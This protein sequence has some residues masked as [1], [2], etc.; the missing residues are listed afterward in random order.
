MRVFNLNNWMSCALLID[1]RSDRNKQSNQNPH[2]LLKIHSNC[3]VDANSIST[4]SWMKTLNK[5]NNTLNKMNVLCLESPTSQNQIN[6]A[7]AKKKEHVAPITNEIIDLIRE[8]TTDFFVETGK[9][10]TDVCGQMKKKAAEAFTQRTDE[11]EAISEEKIKKKS[12]RLKKIKNYLVKYRF[13]FKD[14]IS[15]FPIFLFYKQ[16]KSELIIKKL[17]QSFNNDWYE[18]HYNQIQNLSLNKTVFQDKD[19]GD[20]KIICGMDKDPHLKLTGIAKI[21]HKL[22]KQFSIN[23]LGIFIDPYFISKKGNKLIAEH[24]VDKRSSLF[25]TDSALLDVHNQQKF[26]NLDNDKDFQ[27]ESKINE[28]PDLTNRQNQSSDNV[29]IMDSIFLSTDSN[30]MKSKTG[31]LEMLSVLED[32][33][34]KNVVNDQTVSNTMV[35]EVKLACDHQEQLGILT[36]V[37]PMNNQFISRKDNAT[38]WSSETKEKISNLLLEYQKHLA[39]QYFFRSSEI[40]KQSITTVLLNKLQKSTAQEFSEHV[41]DISTTNILKKHRDSSFIQ[42]LGYFFKRQ[43]E[44]KGTLLLNNIVNELNEDHLKTNILSV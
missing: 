5:L 1:S 30:S 21:F 33:I 28:N 43:S 20:I 24:I 22:E 9:K 41:F 13:S 36:A 26:S 35:N 14:P 18:L 6:L 34:D 25:I 16:C 7:Q 29:S 12:F 4:D 42:K 40:T 11:T 17:S 39:K 31:D 19:E 44:T 38:N 10:I 23:I 32:E 37:Q 2:Y 15:S 3:Q 27:L 8:N